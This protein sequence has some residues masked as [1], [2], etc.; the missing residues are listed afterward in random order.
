REYL[1]LGL[2]SIWDENKRFLNPQEYPV[3]LSKACWDNKHK[4]IFEVAEHVKE[5]EE[6]NE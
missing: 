3:D 6:D 5:M 2:Q 1:A 4:R